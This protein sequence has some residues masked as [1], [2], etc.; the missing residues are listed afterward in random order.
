MNKVSVYAGDGKIIYSE[1]DTHPDSAISNAIEC[2]T[3]NG[4]KDIV[5]ADNQTELSAWEFLLKRGYRV[6]VNE[7]AKPIISNVKIVGSSYPKQ[8]D[9]LS[10]V[11]E[12]IRAMFKDKGGY[13]PSDVL[14]AQLIKELRK[15][16]GFQGE[17]EWSL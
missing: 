17:K 11:D 8:P 4:M 3:M 5:D 15:L 13:F 10:F 6:E 14:S 2:M 12:D 9:Y 7:L 16:N 1:Y